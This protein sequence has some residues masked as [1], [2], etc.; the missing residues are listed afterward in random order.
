[1]LA[2]T[3]KR[4]IFFCENL[5]K[6][7]SEAIILKVMFLMHYALMHTNDALSCALKKSAFNKTKMHYMQ[8]V[9]V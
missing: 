9:E 5:Y 6:F 2:L 4:Q 3:N 7:C 8:W 1:M